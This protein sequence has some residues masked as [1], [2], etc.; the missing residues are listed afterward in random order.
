MSQFLFIIEIPPN[1]SISTE[2]M[3]CVAWRKFESGLD[4][5][6]KPL[7]SVVRLQKNAFLLPSENTWPYMLDIANLAVSLNLPYS[8]SLISGDITHLTK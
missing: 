7:K 6:L 3:Y 4:N 8:V 2:P 5:I 1:E